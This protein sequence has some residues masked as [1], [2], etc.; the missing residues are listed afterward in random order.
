MDCTGV[1]SAS[2]WSITNPPSFSNCSRK[3]LSRSRRKV[4]GNFFRQKS[5][6]VLPV[7]PRLVVLW[8]TQAYP[9]RRFG[10]PP[11]L[12]AFLIA[13]ERRCRGVG[14]RSAGIFTA[15]RLEW[16]CL[17]PHGK[18]SC[19]IMLS[20]VLPL[21]RL[22]AKCLDLILWLASAALRELGA[23]IFFCQRMVLNMLLPLACPL[24]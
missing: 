1:S 23:K 14:E 10:L 5:G 7:A 2:I 12:Q 8:I 20:P 4:G 18:G 22:C 6:M 16:L 17:W 19:G 24:I 11:T 9:A 3:T 13:V 15:R 21:Y